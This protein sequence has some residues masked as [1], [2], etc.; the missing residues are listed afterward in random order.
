MVMDTRNPVRMTKGNRGKIAFLL[1]V[2]YGYEVREHDPSFVE[3]RPPGGDAWVAMRADQD[4]EFD[5]KF[6]DEYKDEYQDLFNLALWQGDDELVKHL[7]RGYGWKL[8][9]PAE[10]V[11]YLHPPSH[12]SEWGILTIDKN[13]ID[14]SHHQVR[15]MWAHLYHGKMDDF[16]HRLKS[17][18]TF[19]TPPR[20]IEIPEALCYP[21][22][23]RLQRGD[24]MSEV[25]DC[26]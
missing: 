21:I 19:T 16:Q 13:D 9:E 24:D 11:Q 15:R 18:R 22:Y 1:H 26:L 3:L 17:S 7:V 8:K 25:W 10:K 5:Q 20:H 23:E 4:D 2:K 12:L 14:G 6:E